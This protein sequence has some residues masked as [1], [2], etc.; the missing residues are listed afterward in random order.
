MFGHYSYLVWMLIFSIVPI[1]LM[2]WRYGQRY[3]WKNIRVIGI[4]A[5]VAVAYQLIADPFAEAWHAWFFDTNEIMDLWIGN[6]PI[7]NVIF[8]FLVSIAISSFI[9]AY[10]ERKERT[11]K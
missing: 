10:I 11:P 1:G 3:L 6:F 2:W 4:V 8:F 9:I 7:E 5:I